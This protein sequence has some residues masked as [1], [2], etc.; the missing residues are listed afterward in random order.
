MTTHASFSAAVGGTPLLRLRHA[1]EATCCEIL[2][3]AEFMNPGGSV[4]ERNALGLLD[5]AERRGLVRSGAML[6]EGTAGTTGIGLA[7]LGASRG[8]RT[9]IVMPDTQSREKID[10]LRVTGADV[11]LVPAAPF[12]DP[13]H[14]VHVARALAEELNG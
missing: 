13:K 5:D 11:R 1:S 8:Y 10:A 12:K 2:A 9:L 6:V 14:Y 7:L 4:K 3:K